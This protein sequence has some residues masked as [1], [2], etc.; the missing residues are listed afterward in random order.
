MKNTGPGTTIRAEIAEAPSAV[1]RQSHG[2]AEP[3]SQLVE[4]CRRKPPRVVL[5]CARGSSAHAAT[6][7]KHLIERHLQI[8]VAPVAPNIATIYRQRLQIRDQLL[9]SI[10][11]SGRS[12]DLI[13]VASMARQAGATTVAIVNDTDS[14][15]AAASAIVL[16][17]AAG[18]EVSVAATKSFIASLAVGLRMVAAWSNDQRLSEA[19]E[20]LP[21]RLRAAAQLDW[22]SHARFLCEA[23][24]LVT[25]GRGP[26]LA[27][28]REA[29]L[30]LKEMCGL[31]AEPFSSAE[32]RHGPMALI[33][34]RYPV[35]FFVPSDEAADGVRELAHDLAR[36]G[37]STLVAADGG[38]GSLPVL[39]PDHADADALCLIQSFYGLAVQLGAWKGLDS[40][41]PQHLQ[42][43]TR[44]R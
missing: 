24:S 41:S 38:I 5:T 23:R 10:S 22:S 29:A 12:D 31:H 6:F 2:L 20:R 42:K 7:I 32:F 15:L 36:K 9:L 34:P 11:Q 28:A 8:P 43:I 13:E 35:L 26:T 18:R 19:T 30:K 25:I 39:V 1:Q 37:A 3:L 17:I 4:Q 44:T 16:P 14:P 33:G 21:A 40:E 27:V